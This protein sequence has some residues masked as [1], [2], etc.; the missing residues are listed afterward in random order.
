MIL[1]HLI[2]AIAIILVFPH[3]LGF[4]WYIDTFDMYI[5]IAGILM[6]AA[7][8]LIGFL[9]IK[10]ALKNIKLTI[11]FLQIG[12]IG[13]IYF[14]IHDLSINKTPDISGFIMRCVVFF[15][16]FFYIHEIKKVD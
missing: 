16:L 4:I 5:S 9:P 10:L 2:R 12:Q 14:G 6:I 1:I 15:L 3:I 13:C 11:R 8:I 7:L